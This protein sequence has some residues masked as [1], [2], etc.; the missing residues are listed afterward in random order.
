MRRAQNRLYNCIVCGKEGTTLSR[1]TK[2]CEDCR[3]LVSSRNVLNGYYRRIGRHDMVLSPDEVIESVKKR[4]QGEYIV[5]EKKYSYK[6]RTKA[7][8]K[9]TTICPLDQCEFSKNGKCLFYFR[10]SDGSESCPNIEA[11]NAA[12]SKK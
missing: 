9:T 12:K 1:N 4:I 5:P 7:I 8:E 11:R 6:K 2:Y 10:Y 3:G